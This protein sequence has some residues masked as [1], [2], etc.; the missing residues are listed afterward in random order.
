MAFQTPVCLLL[1]GLDKDRPL[2]LVVV[3]ANHL[4]TRELTALL[5]H[6]T[7][8]HRASYPRKKARC[9]KDD[10]KFKGNACLSTRV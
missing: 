9:Q 2:G 7:T 3:P 1:N 5:H 6:A 4:T 10:N 8:H